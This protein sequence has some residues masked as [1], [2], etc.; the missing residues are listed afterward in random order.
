MNDAP[1]VQTT[2]DS[3]LGG[4]VTLHQPAVG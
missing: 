4:R 1:S 3:V 2:L